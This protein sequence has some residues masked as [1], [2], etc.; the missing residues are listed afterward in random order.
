MVAP[1][2]GRGIA[3]CNLTYAAADGRFRHQVVR[4]ASGILRTGIPSV[5]LRSPAAELGR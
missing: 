1:L 4:H 2:V 5:K 3:T